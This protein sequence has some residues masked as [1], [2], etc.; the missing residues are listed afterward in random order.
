M[1]DE[2][3]IH[4]CLPHVLVA[5][6]SPDKITIFLPHDDLLINAAEPD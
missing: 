1:S 5:W 6:R 3:V 2:V 4:Q